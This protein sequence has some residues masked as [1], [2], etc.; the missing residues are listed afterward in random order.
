VGEA[1]D[2]VAS[3]GFRIL[4]NAGYEGGKWFAASFADAVRWGRAFQR[5]PR[6]EPFQVVTVVFPRAMLGSMRFHARWDGIGP[7][8]FVEQRH[9]P[10]LNRVALLTISDVFEPE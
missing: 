8:Y 1:V 4:A 9:L 7:A 3:G 10:A 2:V 5:F 6:P